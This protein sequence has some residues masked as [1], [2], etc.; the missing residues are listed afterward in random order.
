MAYFDDD[1][2]ILGANDQNELIE[3]ERL[4]DD[5]EIELLGSEN[6]VP[7]LLD[8]E[9]TER[10]PQTPPATERR[11]AL[12][13]Q[14]VNT[15][16]KKL[17]VDVV[18]AIDLTGSMAKLIDAIKHDVVRFRDWLYDSLNENLQA[19]GKMR[20]LNR[21]RLRVVGYRDYNYDWKAALQPW[22][23][24]MVTSDFFDLDDP[25]DREAL[26]TFVDKLEATGGEDE[27]ESALEALHYAI[28]SDW[29]RD[30]TVVH[31]HV[32]ILCTDAPA[33]PL[34]GDDQEKRNVGNEHYPADADMPY[35]LVQLQSEYSNPAVIDQSAQRLLIFAPKDAYPWSQVA[36]WNG[37]S[38]C[39]VEL[40]NGLKKVGMDAILAALS[41]S[42][43]SAG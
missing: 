23:G 25:F 2:E 37:G 10:L 35:D 27:P 39:D 29:D 31:R 41:G 20:T 1:M 24:P 33:H 3:P 28:H 40:N 26:Q 38:I 21:M 19:K 4:G 36:Q 13:S 6:F 32:I 5:V 9:E 7:I 43:G 30:E 16:G 14:A 8:T 42:I 34:T 11:A 15:G 12:A 17:N 18:M 22:H